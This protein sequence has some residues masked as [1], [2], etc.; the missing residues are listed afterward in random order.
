[1]QKNLFY[2][3]CCIV[4]IF[5]VK[6]HCEC[7]DK[8]CYSYKRQAS[9]ANSFYVTCYRCHQKDLVHSLTDTEIRFHTDKE[10]NIFPIVTSNILLP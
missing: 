3:Y 9:V 10:D 7:I 8:R 5:D 6:A 4:P 2:V 1:M